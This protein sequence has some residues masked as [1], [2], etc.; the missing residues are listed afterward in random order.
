[1]ISF[2]RIVLLMLAVAVLA[3]SASAALLGK[4]E[5]E[6]RKIKGLVIDSQDTPIPGAIVFLKNLRRNRTLS[7]ATGDDGSFLFPDVD[8]KADFEIH[9]EYK[10][11]S[12]STRSLPSMDPR[13]TIILNLK[14][15][16]Q[17]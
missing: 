3:P 17:K 15:A 13:L 1:M 5:P 7:V 10:G 8:R 16:T 2:R 14:I 4:K 9:A 11:A 6:V 12:S